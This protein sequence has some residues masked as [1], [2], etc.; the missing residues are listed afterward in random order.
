MTKHLDIRYLGPKQKDNSHLWEIC[1]VPEGRFLGHIRWRK[2]QRMYVYEGEKGD[3]EY[4]IDEFV[5][6]LNRQQ[7][8]VV[9]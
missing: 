8:K 4:E 5:G 2:D 1:D 9:Q 7:A 6:E 3:H